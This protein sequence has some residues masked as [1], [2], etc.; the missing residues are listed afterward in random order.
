MAQLAIKRH[1]TRGSEVIALLEMLG[2]ENRVFVLLNVL[3]I[4]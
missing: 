3:N 2:G 1:P 4:N